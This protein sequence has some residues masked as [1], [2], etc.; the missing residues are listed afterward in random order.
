MNQRKQDDWSNWETKSDEKAPKGI[1]VDG[2]R[3]YWKEYGPNYVRIVDTGEIIKREKFEER[4]K[5]R[6]TSAVFLDSI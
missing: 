5:D 3:I 6:I 2:K 4:Y 1:V